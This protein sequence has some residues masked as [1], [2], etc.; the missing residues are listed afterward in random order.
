MKQS[1]QT[2]SLVLVLLLVAFVALGGCG[3]SGNDAEAADEVSSV[4]QT[5]DDSAADGLSDGFEPGQMASASAEESERVGAHGYSTQ[6]IWVDNGGASI[7]GLAYIPDD[8]ASA[9]LVVFAHE[10]SNDHTAG[11]AY[12][13]VLASHGYAVYTFDFRGGS[14]NGNRSD[15]ISTEM[16]VMT[17]VGDFAAV[18]D[19]AK[20]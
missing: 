7:Y 5:Q 15:E 12:A 8:V 1:L 18:V 6:E 14:V 19:A 20:G 9:P 17:E 2:L 10:L 11:E 3:T 16:S 4:Q 13:R